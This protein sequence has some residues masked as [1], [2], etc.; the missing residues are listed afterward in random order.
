MR[1]V[2]LANSFKGPTQAEWA[3]GRER[4]ACRATMICIII[5]HALTDACADELSQRT[6]TYP[7]FRMPH[8]HFLGFISFVSIQATGTS[9]TQ[10][11][12]EGCASSRRPYSSYETRHSIAN[13]IQIKQL[14]ARA[15]KHC[16]GDGEKAA[17]LSTAC[18]SA[19]VFTVRLCS[20]RQVG[21]LLLA[22]NAAK[23]TRGPGNSTTPSSWRSPCLATGW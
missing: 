6:A 9:R 21:S 18:F 10:R 4:P 19:V 15:W 14:I 13:K 22:K 12:P 1:P 11:R 17:E 7:V 8:S 2:S 23:G 16:T 3:G 20:P 5:C